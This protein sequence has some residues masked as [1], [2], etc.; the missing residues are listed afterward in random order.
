MTSDDATPSP[1]SLECPHCLYPVHGAASTTHRCP[2]CGAELNLLEL[3]DALRDRRPRLYERT[4]ATAVLT[5]VALFVTFGLGLL[6][7]G[8][9]FALSEP[10]AVVVIIVILSLVVVTP[11]LV[12]LRNGV[13]HLI[14]SALAFVIVV[15]FGIVAAGGLILFTN[16]ASPATITLGL[17]VTIALVLGVVLNVWL[18]RWCL[19]WELRERV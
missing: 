2:E 15:L 19:R 16:P 17:A 4:M 7:V 10:A 3:R 12:M 1:P 11:H 14:A 5:V 8:P 6:I 13:R 18:R 9:F